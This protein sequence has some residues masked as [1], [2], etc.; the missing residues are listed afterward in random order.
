MGVQLDEHEWD[1]HA[2]C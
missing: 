1:W 2:V